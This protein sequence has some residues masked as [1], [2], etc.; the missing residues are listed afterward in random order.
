MKPE[1]H[2]GNFIV[3]SLATCHST[4]FYLEYVSYK[5]ILLEN[6][7]LYIEDRASIC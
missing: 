4:P 3:I 2:T 5:D 7:G 1:G 6:K